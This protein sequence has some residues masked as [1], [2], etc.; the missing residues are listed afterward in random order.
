[1][2]KT[3]WP[4]SALLPVPISPLP[5]FL[6]LFAF[7]Q[8]GN[9]LARNEPLL[10]DIIFNFNAGE[11]LGLSGAHG[12]VSV[13]QCVL[14]LVIFPPSFS[15]F[16]S[17]IAAHPWASNVR[18]FVNLEVCLAAF[19]TSRAASPFFLQTRNRALKGPST[20]R[21]T[22]ARSESTENAPEMIGERY[23]RHPS[24]FTH[25]K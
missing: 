16:P 21:T 1:V 5:P 9:L 4:P 3:R 18:C 2:S 12:C 7:L 13:V 6:C 10:H 11:E 19:S 23:E 20:V 15:M 25:K 8:V 22:T 14:L 24:E 17:F